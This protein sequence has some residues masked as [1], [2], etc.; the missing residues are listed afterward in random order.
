LTQRQSRRV[1]GD[2]SEKVDSEDPLSEATSVGEEETALEDALSEATSADEETALEDLLSEAAS[3][4]E[5]VTPLED[6]LE[7]SQHRRLQ[8]RKKWIRY[9][10]SMLS[11][12][13]TLMFLP[14]KKKISM[15]SPSKTLT[16]LP[17]TTR[18]RPVVSCVLTRNKT[19]RTNGKRMLILSKNMQSTKKSRSTFQTK[20]MPLNL[21]KHW[22]TMCY[23]KVQMLRS[24]VIREMIVTLNITAI[25]SYRLTLYQQR[26]AI[27]LDCPINRIDQLSFMP[28]QP[29]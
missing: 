2:D 24:S 18:K 13:K 12:W 9:K 3:A 5:E 15:R 20:G 25:F 23:A 29:Q 28:R 8:F 16:C 7:E 27:R 22:K 10:R 6:F 4:D 17:S 11:L 19:S 14:P 21:V 1:Q 26:E